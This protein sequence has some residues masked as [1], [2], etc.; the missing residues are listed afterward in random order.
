MYGLAVS[1]IDN[2]YGWPSFSGK[3]TYLEPGWADPV[4]NHTLTAYVEDH[5]EP[6]ADKVWVEVRHKDGV[7]LDGLSRPRQAHMHVVLLQDGNIVVAHGVSKKQNAVGFKGVIIRSCP[8]DWSLDEGLLPSS[9]ENH[10]YGRGFSLENKTA[11]G[12]TLRTKRYLQ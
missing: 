6:G 5:G 9:Q 3:A 8:P 7:V 12:N 2:P 11:S 10:C 1:A 4:G